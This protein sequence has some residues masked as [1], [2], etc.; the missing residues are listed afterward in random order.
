VKTK[1]TAVVLILII[2]CSCIASCG[3]T[4]TVTTPPAKNFEATYFPGAQVMV[5]NIETILITSKSKLE[6]QKN[7]LTFYRARDEVIQKM[8]SYSDDFF[9]TKMLI[10]INMSE[11]TISSVITVE[12]VDFTDS[13]AI[14]TL[15][16]RRPRSDGEIIKIW[17]IFVEVEAREIE[18]VDYTV[19]EE[20]FE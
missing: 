4:P 16:R 2:I 7:S 14:V 6:S 15:K 19:T 5:K 17:S 1:I 8:D 12:N 3:S 13:K 20:I 9:E 18:S 10:I 11:P